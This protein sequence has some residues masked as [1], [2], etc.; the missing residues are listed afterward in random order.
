MQPKILITI[1]VL[2]LVI[3]SKTK[4][5]L[6]HSTATPSGNWKAVASVL[7]L[8]TLYCGWGDTVNKKGILLQI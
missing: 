5:S 3:L 1:F 8:V 6:H 2:T 4:S 7:P